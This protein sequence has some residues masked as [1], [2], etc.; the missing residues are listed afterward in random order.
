[1]FKMIKTTDESEESKI[2]FDSFDI[3]QLFEQIIDSKFWLIF[4]NKES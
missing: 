1:M 2:G 3:Q 4:F